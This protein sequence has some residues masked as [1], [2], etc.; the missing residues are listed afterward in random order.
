VRDKEKASA[1]A[2]R[3]VVRDKEKVSAQAE[4][5][6]VRDK[7]KASAQAERSVVRDKEMNRPVITL[8]TDFG[9][10]DH[11]A[12]AM[13]GVILDICPD[14]QL[15]DIS[16]EVTPYAITEAAFTLSQA[17]VCFPAGSIHLVVVD[18]GVGSSR[19]PILVEAEGHLFVAPDNGVLT[20]VYGAAPLHEVREITAS[21]YF[22][23]PVSR[24]FHG[25]DIFGPVA[26]Q[27]ANGLAPDEAGTRIGDYLRLGFAMPVRT[28]HRT[29]AG[30]I[31]K[32]D[33]F[34]NV[35]TN[36]DSESW[37]RLAVER[38]EM[39]IGQRT[40]AR[41]ASNYAEVDEGELFV[42]AGSAG[43]LEISMNRGSAAKTAGARSGDALEIR[44]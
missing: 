37:Q 18:P 25:R 20:M 3:S 22:R 5:S 23:K 29:W 26:A 16:H 19:R 30:T 2:E 42:I 34:G 11:Y 4:R 40:V 39:K 44:L 31:L 24:T 8:L 27:L 12:G 14:A 41:T 32:V 9:A 7:E 33:R 10:G 15:V 21:R 36:F 6:V 17:W 28:G 35:I 38:F 1:Q 43:F 13:K